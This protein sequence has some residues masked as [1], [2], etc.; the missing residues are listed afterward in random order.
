VGEATL[1]RVDPTID[2]NWGTDAPDPSISLDFF[3][4]RWEGQ[5]Q[6]LYTDTYTFYTTTD[7]GARL[8][9][10]GQQI[11]DRWQNQAATTAS[12]TI[13]LVA[14]QKYNLVMEYYENTSTASA[15]LSWSS[16]HQAREIIPSTQLYPTLG[17]SAITVSI[18]RVDAT[19]LELNWTG[20]ASIESAD[21]I[22][23]Q[24]NLVANNVTAPYNVPVSGT[25]KFFRVATQN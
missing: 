20:T 12:G 17:P 9:V 16:L 21:S 25:H 7:D 22:E 19:T 11:V 14:G 3:M 2:F 6:P 5:V 23:G 13:S 8:W 15:Q 18:R 4:V 1:T 10:N 24:W